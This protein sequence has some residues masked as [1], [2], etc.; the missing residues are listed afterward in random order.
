MS[1]QEILIKLPKIN[2]RVRVRVWV[3]TS[4]SKL[5]K[6]KEKWKPRKPSIQRKLT[7]FNH[8]SFNSSEVRIFFLNNILDL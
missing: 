7:E 4:E 6:P 5:L 2:V 3:V 1:H 8:L